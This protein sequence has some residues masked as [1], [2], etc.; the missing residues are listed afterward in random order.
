MPVTPEYRAETVSILN[1]VAPVTGR[2]MFGGVGLYCQGLFFALMAEDRLYFKV[3]SSNRGD[4]EAAGM[5]PFHPFGDSSQVMHYYEVPPFVLDN[6]DELAAWMDKALH[7]AETKK[8][9]APTKPSKKAR[10]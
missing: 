1:L 9:K 3:D 7:V 4:Y 6:P 10:V 5:E 8:A 2:G